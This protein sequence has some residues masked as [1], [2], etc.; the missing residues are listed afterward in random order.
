MI[1]K[2]TL[3]LFLAFLLTL[4]FIFSGPFNSFCIPKEVIGIS[5][6]RDT[7]EIELGKNTY[8]KVFCFN[9]PFESFKI[10]PD[11]NLLA[12]YSAESKILSIAE[13][14]GKNI[15]WQAETESPVFGWLPNHQNILTYVKQD[16]NGFA[17]INI[18]TT[19]L[20]EDSIYEFFRENSLVSYLSWSPKGNYLAF[21]SISGLEDSH[22]YSQLHIIDK[23]YSQKASFFDVDTISWALDEEYIAFSR[24]TWEDYSEAKIELY[25]L[26]TSQS[27]MLPLGEKLQLS[28]LFTQD[29]KGILYTSFK[30]FSQ[31]LN[32]FDLSNNKTR[33]LIPNLEY[34]HNLFWLTKDLLVF[35]NGHNPNI[36][37]YNIQT[38]K[39]TII[40]QGYMPLVL[41]NSIY[42]VKNNF[43]NQQMELLKY[44]NIK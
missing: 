41:H 1:R 29:G 23:N 24:F 11:E 22:G 12:F 25:N 2:K 20:I 40:D 33:L 10:S 17:L 18:N 15:V 14:S 37:T 8:E 4:L 32:Y 30:N 42:Y 9:E 36:F 27:K 7:S 19:S 43:I 35:T 26:K 6:Q 21:L 31:E 38:N 3:Y 34:L 44:T 5:S 16:K 28:P 13:I 39:F